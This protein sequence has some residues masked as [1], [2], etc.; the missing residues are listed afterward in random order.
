MR[1]RATNR[2][3]AAV[4]AFAGLL[5]FFVGPAIDAP[6]P[7]GSVGLVACAIAVGLPARVF[8]IG[9]PPA[10]PGLWV[11]R[12]PLLMRMASWLLA[13]GTAIALASACEF[14]IQFA[15]VDACLDAG[16]RWD[17]ERDQ[18]EFAPAR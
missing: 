7:S 2:T 6:G 15:D 10:E 17:H 16:G 11:F 3:A 18:C 12:R 1:I 8:V 13:A 5:L 14:V 4:G 9:A